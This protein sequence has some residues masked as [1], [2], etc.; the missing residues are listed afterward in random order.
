MLSFHNLILSLGKVVVISHANTTIGVSMAGEG[1]RDYPACIGYQSPWYKE[2]SFVEDHFARVGVAMTRGKP[3]TRVAVIHPIES[4]WLAF[5]PNG[6]GDELGVRDKAFSDLTYWL[7]HGL[8]DFDFI[9]ES[10]LPGQVPERFIDKKLHVGHCKY[11]VVIVPNL[12]TI[13]STTLQVLRNFSKSGGQVIIAGSAPELVD[14]QIPKSPPFIEHSKSVLWGWQ[15]ILSALDRYRDLRILTDEKLPLGRL[16]YQMR[17][18]GPHRFVFICN[19]ERT[20][21][22]ETIVELKGHWDVEKL[23]TLTGGESAISSSRCK[24]GWTRFPYKFEGCASLLLRLSPSASSPSIHDLGSTVL[25]A[26]VDT[27]ATSIPIA[28]HGVTLSEPNVLL[29]DYAQ[30][31]LSTSA[32]PDTWS[33]PTEVLRIDNDVRSHLGLPL[34]SSVYRQPWSVPESQRQEQAHLALRFAFNSSFTVTEATQLALEDAEKIKILINNQPITKVKGYWVDECISTLA[35]PPFTI[36]N[37][38]NII[39]LDLPFNILTNLERIYILGPFLVDVL[40]RDASI[41]PV[42]TSLNF[43]SIVEQGLPFYAGN[44]TYN[45]SFSTSSPA[46]NVTLHVPDFE[47]PVLAV[48]STPTAKKLGRIALQPRTL[49][50]GELDA[51]RH[52]ISITAYGNRNNAFGHIHCSAI[53]PGWCDPNMWRSISLSSALFSIIPS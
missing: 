1:K 11:D 40:G 50:L 39:T 47:S 6:S 4:Y 52:E 48:H 19:V 30:Y 42:T 9:S 45:C 12:R 8:I 46:K 21:A 5:G 38:K 10:L 16:L 51:G 26:T 15:S 14:A 33:P 35:I 37:G 31:K 7:I 25:P 28:L 53:N 24:N 3:L 17:E 2:Y 20:N 44:V 23:D 32:T 36:K 41:H 27:R 49:E 13:R 29:L 18:D 34:K 22:V 43:G